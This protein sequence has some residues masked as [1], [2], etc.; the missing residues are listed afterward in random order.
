MPY[1]SRA[2][3]AEL[4]G[5]VFG[6]VLRGVRSTCSRCRPSRFYTWNDTAEY[7]EMVHY[8]RKG[9]LKCLDDDIFPIKHDSDT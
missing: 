6:N 7:Q 8:N 3:C 4:W 2:C 5:V 1:V 9:R